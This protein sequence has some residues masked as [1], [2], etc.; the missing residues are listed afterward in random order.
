[1]ISFILQEKAMILLVSFLCFNVLLSIVNPKQRF[2][3]QK[4]LSKSLKHEVSQ[5]ATIRL[6]K[7]HLPSVIV[8]KRLARRGDIT[9]LF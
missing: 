4:F 5:D 8:G 9:A 6:Y 2:D 1:M 3:Y 7:P